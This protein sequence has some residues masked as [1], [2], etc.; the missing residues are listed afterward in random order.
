LRS[1]SNK[2]FV[3][4]GGLRCPV[5][6]RVTMDQIIVDVTTVA[7]S[8]HLPKIADEAVVMGTQKKET[9]SADDLAHWGGTISYEILCALGSR[10][11]RIYKE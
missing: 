3:L 11:P 4:I 2:S 6:G 9:I 5:I 7:F 8:G 10:L 1:L